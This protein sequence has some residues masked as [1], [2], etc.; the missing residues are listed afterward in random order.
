MDQTVS[1]AT[2]HALR[3]LGAAT[4]YEAQG[5]K[6][7]LDS[8]IKPIAPGM[9][10]AGP[11]L[12]VDTRPADNLML[13]YAMLKAR[14]GDVL[15]VDAKGFMEAGVWG[16][17]FTEQAQRIGLAGLVIHGA[18]RD[19]AAMTQAGFPVFSR[20][21][22]I[23]G[24][25]KHQPGRLNVTITIGDVGIDPGDII[26]GDQDGVVVV[27]RHEVDDVLL[28]SRQREEKE[29]QF[30]QQIRDGA[31]TVELLGLDETLRRLQL[32]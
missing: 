20:G 22:S 1:I 16:D 6:G 29:A 23:K 27:R 3:Q 8:G 28:K 21:L 7:A 10:L 32:G 5:A 19:A 17:V 11:A 25:G 4:I 18:V 13:H 30:R 9:R 31:T 12:T 24:T 15:V 2:L 14:P 26:V